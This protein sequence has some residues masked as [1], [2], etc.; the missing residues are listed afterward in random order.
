LRKNSGDFPLSSTSC[1]NS[2]T[3]GL[4]C[5]SADREDI[6][7]LAAAIEANP[8]L[9]LVVDVALRTS[10]APTYFPTYQGY[11]DGAV[12]ANNPA[13]AALAQALDAG[14]GKE[15]LQNVHLFSL[16]TGVNPAYV[17]GKELDWGYAQWAKPLIALMVDGMMGVADYQCARLLQ[18]GYFRLAPIL[19]E[20][21][22]LDDVDK[23]ADLVKYAQDVDIQ[24]AVAWLTRYF[25]P[26]SIDNSTRL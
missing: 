22:G 17:A 18:D 23:I 9:E 16:G 14:T 6:A 5:L 7:R 8:S 20:R 3:L 26:A 13:M 1:G 24:G 4:P 19:P 2:I 15:A 25:S 12:V 21:I 10:A 11:I